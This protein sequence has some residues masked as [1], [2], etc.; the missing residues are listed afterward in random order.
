MTK[1]RNLVLLSLTAV[2]GQAHAGLHVCGGK[3][4]VD[5]GTW[6]DQPAI[7]CATYHETLRPINWTGSYEIAH[8][9]YKY[10][11][12]FEENCTGDTA[13]YVFHVGRTD[14]DS[15]THTESGE[16]TM[17]VGYEVGKSDVSTAK[18]Q[19]AG[20]AS[21]SWQWVIQSSY[22]ATTDVTQSIPKCDGRT[23]SVYFT[24]KEY[25]AK[26]WSLYD[27]SYTRY[28][29]G[30]DGILPP[31][32]VTATFDY[33]TS[34]ADGTHKGYLRRGQLVDNGAPTDCTGVACHGSEDVQGSS[35]GS[36]TL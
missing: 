34:Y 23:Y 21:A 33:T 6:I 30:S 28:G 31:Q 1:F 5:F 13:N 2:W 24:D 27:V 11:S 14:T 36:G 12:D 7:D 19:G 26:G 22:Q 8:A 15:L 25:V 4:D 17:S 9:E 10:I 20:T 35:T 32:Q 16:L 29:M 3:A 18:V